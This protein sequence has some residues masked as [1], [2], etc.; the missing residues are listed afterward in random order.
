[1]VLSGEAIAE[2]TTTTMIVQVMVDEGHPGYI[3]KMKIQVVQGRQARRRRIEV[4]APG[5]RRETDFLLGRDP[6][7]PARQPTGKMRTTHPRAVQATEVSQV[8]GEHRR[9]HRLDPMPQN[10]H[11]TCRNGLEKMNKTS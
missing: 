1:M 8:A 4:K 3:L 10:R 5:D 7:R 6:S 2:M 11:D 9:I